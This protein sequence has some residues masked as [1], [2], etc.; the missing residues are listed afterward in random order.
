MGINDSY[1]IDEYLEDLDKEEVLYRYL[2]RIEIN[3]K[4]IKEIEKILNILEIREECICVT[5]RILNL[6]LS[7]Y[8]KSDL[9]KN[10]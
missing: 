3:R 2:R 4:N 6:K 8:Y 1:I 9:K 5:R 7:K 10:V